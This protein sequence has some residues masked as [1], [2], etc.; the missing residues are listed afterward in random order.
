MELQSW[1]SWKKSTIG[2][3]NLM[4]HANF[5]YFLLENQHVFNTSTA[6]SLVQNPSEFSNW[7]PTSGKNSA[8]VQR[9]LSTWLASNQHRSLKQTFTPHL[10]NSVSKLR[11]E[12]MNTDKLWWVLADIKYET[13]T[14]GSKPGRIWR[15]LAFSLL[16]TTTDAGPISYNAEDWLIRRE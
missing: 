6:R 8:A 2:L 4:V 9:L 14:I 3:Y 12:R 1:Q 15:S 7:F 16:H 13:G 11:G 10:R 5:S